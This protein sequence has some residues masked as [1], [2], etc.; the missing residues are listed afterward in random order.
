M[1]PLRTVINSVVEEEA[2]TRTVDEVATQLE[3]VDSRNIKPPPPH[4]V[5]DQ[6][7]KYVGE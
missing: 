2:T 5:R 3:A 1:F 4:L 6:S 7:A